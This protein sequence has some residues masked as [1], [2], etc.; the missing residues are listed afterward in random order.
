MSLKAVHICFIVL[1]TIL[2]LGFGAW[3]FRDCLVSRSLVSHLMGIAS[4]VGGGVLIGY[5]FWFIDKMRK[6]SPS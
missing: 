4:F 6:V 5:L 3:A 2:A 1:S